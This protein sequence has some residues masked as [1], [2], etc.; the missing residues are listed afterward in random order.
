MGRV[1]RSFSFCEQRENLRNDRNSEKVG[2]ANA[3][4]A[5]QL[6]TENKRLKLILDSTMARVQAS[7]THLMIQNGSLR[8]KIERLKITISSEPTLTDM[9]NELGQV[10]EALVIA[11]AERNR[12]QVALAKKGM[13]AQHLS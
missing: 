5:H 2:E 7:H 1:G 6:A 10:R 8:Q 3:S 4:T 9:I 12:L 11:S 13:S